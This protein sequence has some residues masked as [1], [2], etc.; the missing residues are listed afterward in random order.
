MITINLHGSIDLDNIRMFDSWVALQQSKNKKYQLGMKINISP[1][2]FEADLNIMYYYL[3]RNLSDEEVQKYD[4]VIMSND[5]EPI[6]VASSDMFKYT[7]GEFSNVY[8]MVNALVDKD[9]VLHDRILWYTPSWQLSM[10][11]WMQE[12]YPQRFE[13]AELSKLPRAPTIAGINGSLRANRYHFA[14]LLHQRLPDIQYQSNLSTNVYKL[15][16][17][18]WES[19][20]D[21]EF[22]EYINNLYQTNEE[23]QGYVG[24][25]INI[26]FDQRYGE[27][28]GGYFIMPEYYKHSCIIFPES[29]WVNHT[30]APTEKA[31]KCFYA[32][33]LPFPVAGAGANQKYNSIGFFTAWNLLPDKLKEFDSIQNHHDRFVRAID[34]IEWLHANPGVFQSELFY[35]LT[36]RNKLNLLFGQADHSS[37]LKLDSIIQSKLNKMG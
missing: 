14:R 25:R 1:G 37:V 24:N 12:Y 9:H 30:L 13:N 17:C 15:K 28:P 34:A 19:D 8:L 22:R 4:L 29:S 23:P 10:N 21:V 32:G 33:S 27:V 16:T 2:H 20:E 7:T 36:T 31:H 5:G 26:G 18:A 35:E 6:E 11:C 3:P